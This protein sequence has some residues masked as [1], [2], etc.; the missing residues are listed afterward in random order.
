MAILVKTFQE[1]GL[2]FIQIFH[3]NHKKTSNQI[4]SKVPILLSWFVS[5]LILDINMHCNCT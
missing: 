2:A 4:V 3:A 5:R 1:Q